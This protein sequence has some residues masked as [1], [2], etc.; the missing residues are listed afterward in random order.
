[1]LKLCRDVFLVSSVRGAR[2]ASRGLGSEEPSV[3]DAPGRGQPAEGMS[4]RA[5]AAAASADM[6][7][8][9]MRARR[10][11]HGFHAAV[12]AIGAAALTA[13]TAALVM[14]PAFER[15]R[16]GVSDGLEADVSDV[17]P[18]G[19]AF[20]STMLRITGG[21][22]GGAAGA[23]TAFELASASV[24]G[25]GAG[26]AAR[27]FASA[28]LAVVG[29]V[30]CAFAGAEFAEPA[31]TLGVR[32][33]RVLAS[34]SAGF[35]ADVAGFSLGARRGNDAHEPL[36]KTKV[37]ADGNLSATGDP[38]K[39][40]AEDSRRAFARE[41][42]RLREREALLRLERDRVPRGARRDALGVALA[43]IEG[44][45]KALKRACVETHGARL[46]RVMSEDVARAASELAE[47]RARQ[48]ALRREAAAAAANG[49]KAARAR[50]TREAKTLDRAK[51]R[52]KTEAAATF[53]ARLA[54][55]APAVEK[56]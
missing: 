22:L 41:L 52:L 14:H 1:M 35:A 6:I 2:S 31:A 44:A 10:V 5:A 42:V 48:L 17:M 30:A 56:R 33:G 51:K 15:T 16:A 55:H 13:A 27:G 38:S 26:G 4:R 29:G 50:L 49:D 39:P 18:G 21:C 12:P 20:Q 43:E 19:D 7:R 34:G 53:G 40:F 24:A 37:A 45:K 8:R 11:E 36:L 25:G 28:P 47:L 54:K 32:V 3:P 46:G 23:R 9:G